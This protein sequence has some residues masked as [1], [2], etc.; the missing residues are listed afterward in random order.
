MDNA[1]DAKATRVLIRFGTQGDRLVRVDVADDGTGMDDAGIT[2]AMILGRRRDYGFD[3]LGHFGMGLKAASL[4]HADSLTVWS[5]RFASSPAGRRIRRADFSRDFTCELLSLEAAEHADHLRAT[6]AGGQSGTLVV[7]TDVTTRYSGQRAAEARAWITN[8]VES[9]RT[10]LAVTFHRLIRDER[11]RILTM[12][13]QLGDHV[14]GIGQPVLAIDPFG[15]HLSGAPGYPKM[16]TATVEGR[17]ISFECH[18][19]PPKTDTTGFRIGGHPGEAHQGFFVYRRDRLLH[20]GG[21]ADTATASP[22]RQLA[23]VMLDDDATVG[24]LVIMNSEK[25]GLRFTSA[26]R[27]AVGHARAQDG[28]TFG[29]YLDEAEQVQKMALKRRRTRKPAALPEKGFAPKLRR[30]VAEELEDARLGP[31]RAQWKPLGDAD[32]FDIDHEERTIWLN[33]RYRYLFAPERGS[34]N[35]AP[36]LKSLM[37]LLCHHLFEGQY[38]GSKDKD[39]IALFRSVLSE[40]VATEEKMRGA[41]P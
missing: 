22:A 39:E 29:H 30:V 18:I 35:D 34:L 38:L 19:W 3:D 14:E 1:V 36:V 5:R 28:T 9:V 12:V 33:A 16:L 8:E 25:Q 23:R 7:W 13:D 24:T 26:F 32:F 6:L 31:V 20:L 10:H 37:Y 2:S 17:A 15:Y 21:W 11:I 40:A 27:E 4:G 41:L